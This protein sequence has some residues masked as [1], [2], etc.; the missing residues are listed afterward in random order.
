METGYF[1]G[2]G[3]QRA[4]VWDDDMGPALLHVEEGRPFPP[5]G[6]ST[7]QALRRSGVVASAGRD[8]F[9]TTGAVPASTRRGVDA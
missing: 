7:S 1:R 6:S 5:V 9:L 4:A 3:E 8:E 2:V